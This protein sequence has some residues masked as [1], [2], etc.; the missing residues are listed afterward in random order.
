MRQRAQIAVNSAQL[1]SRIAKT[2]TADLHTSD[3]TVILDVFVDCEGRVRV[4]ML[5][6]LRRFLKRQQVVV[7]VVVDVGSGLLQIAGGHVV[8]GLR[9]LHVLDEA[10]I[11]AGSP[12][13]QRRLRCGVWGCFAGRVITDATVDVGIIFA[14]RIVGPG[15]RR[16]RRFVVHFL[17]IP[18]STK[19]LKDGLNFRRTIDR[20]TAAI[21]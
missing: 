7:F 8:D 2:G 15:E 9:Q 19:I 11:S 21:Y 14:D 12:P 3:I 1:P 6:R 13:F 18:N 4:V 16:V 17:K 20:I 10:R 5:H